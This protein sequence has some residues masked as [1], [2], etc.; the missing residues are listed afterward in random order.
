MHMA[1][2]ILVKVQEEYSL[3]TLTSISTEI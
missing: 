3:S 2:Y 1:G